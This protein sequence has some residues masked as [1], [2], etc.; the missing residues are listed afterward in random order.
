MYTPEYFIDNGIFK[1]DPERNIPPPPPPQLFNIREDPLEQ[2]D[3]TETAPDKVREL[4]NKLENWFEDVETD[5]QSI[6]DEWQ[7]NP[8]SGWET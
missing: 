2:N 5:R 8:E 3:L 1:G 6:A 4:E 7:L